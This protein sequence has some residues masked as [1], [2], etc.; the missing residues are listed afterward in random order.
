MWQDW[1]DW[2]I[3]PAKALELRDATLCRSHK[4]AKSELP[5]KFDSDAM[6]EFV[7][8][9]YLG[10]SFLNGAGEMHTKLPSLHKSEEEMADLVRTGAISRAVLDEA[11]SGEPSLAHNDSQEVNKTLFMSPDSYT[12]HYASAFYKMVP[13]WDLR[14]RE[15]ALPKYCRCQVASWAEG[16]R[17]AA[18]SG[19]VAFELCLG[20]GPLEC[21][22]QPGWAGR[23]DMVDTSNV[24][25]QTGLAPLLLACR[26]VVSV[27]DGE[28]RT[29]S[30]L[31]P[32]FSDDERSY[33]ASEL[34]LSPS[35]WPAAYGWWCNGH[36]DGP[37]AAATG[38]SSQAAELRVGFK[39][40][41]LSIYAE[42]DFSW[43]PAE[44]SCRGREDAGE[45]AVRL[46][47][48][49]LVREC[50]SYPARRPGK[51]TA[52][53]CGVL[54]PVL[55]RLSPRPLE[56]L[57]S[58]EV[59]DRIRSEAQAWL[60]AILGQPADT[61]LAPLMVRAC[62]KEPLLDDDA[63]LR[64]RQPVLGAQGRRHGKLCDFSCLQLG[65][66]RRGHTKW[67]GFLVPGDTSLDS[68]QVMDLKNITVI[69]NVAFEF[70]DAHSEG[71][72]AVLRSMRSCFCAPPGPPAMP[73]GQQ[74]PGLLFR[75]AA[76]GAPVATRKSAGNAADAELCNVTRV[77][78][79]AVML[80]REQYASRAALPE[81]HKVSD[82]DPLLELKELLMAV[83]AVPEHWTYTFLLKDGAGGVRLALSGL[84]VCQD[85]LSGVP[86]W[87]VV[88]HEPTG[89]CSESRLCQLLS[90][91][92][93]TSRD[94]SATEL[95]GPA[96][97]LFLRLVSALGGRLQEERVFHGRDLP[98]RGC[99]LLFP[100]MFPL[101]SDTMDQMHL[102]VALEME[103]GIRMLWDSPAIVMEALKTH[104]NSLMAQKAY[105]KAANVYLLAACRMESENVDPQD[106]RLRLLAAQCQ[107]QPFSSPHESSRGRRAQDLGRGTCWKKQHSAPQPPSVLKPAWEKAVLS[108]WNV[109]GA[110]R[111]FGCGTC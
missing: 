78:T 33:L 68:L 111:R 102:I 19:R 28:L 27:P 73:P 40:P 98:G 95:S 63:R 15:E 69:S 49:G 23:F 96:C 72:S 16:L 85:E 109:P 44:D 101:R 25:D 6:R 104:A 86:L 82:T 54:I 47:L 37:G 3:G 55:A 36:G 74:V 30:L 1:L 91:A 93:P 97:E 11:A 45:D 9:G 58:L 110:G 70:D 79:S 29:T 64:R 62:F 60:G 87:D 12:L 39:W 106:D 67:A 108:A 51:P 94:V 92:S 84:A 89:P 42:I 17:Q 5:A 99:R 46:A 2:D 13:L 53:H 21:L 76:G 41:F 38:T 57:E 61:G 65:T 75:K 48:E 10:G 43:R 18:A 88:I 14:P 107:L 20:D 100:M 90:K 24:A 35:W 77:A 52:L 34:Q 56:L 50:S 32:Q 59:P 26:R 105:S 22:S 80:K 4:C 31:F 8:R 81:S 103:L 71:L 7:R 66:D 83:F